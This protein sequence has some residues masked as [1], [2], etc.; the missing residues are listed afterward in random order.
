MSAGVAANRA[1]PLVRRWRVIEIERVQLSEVIHPLNELHVTALCASFQL[2]GGELLI[3]PIVVDESLQLIDGLHRITAAKRLGWRFISAVVFEQVDLHDRALLFAEAN[4][5]RKRISVLD[6]EREWRKLYAP[7]LEYQ[8][9]QRR[10]AGLQ[11]RFPHLSARASSPTA[12][13]VLPSPVIG[14]SNN[15]ETMGALEYPPRAESLAKAAKRITG[16]SI[17]TLN[18]VRAI[19]EIAESKKAPPNVQAAAQLGLKKIAASRASVDAVHRQLCSVMRSEAQVVAGVEVSST[20]KEQ[21]ET[22]VERLVVDVTL[23]AE[24]LGGS[25]FAALRNVAAE[26]ESAV[27][28]IAGIRSSLAIALGQVAAA[29]SLRSEQPEAEL[30][31]IMIEAGKL[32]TSTANER[33]RVAAQTP[34]ERLSNAA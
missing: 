31:R 30:C 9:K 19:R 33:L 15:R 4:R 13:S 34:S 27:Q 17:D 16:F 21:A 23:L 26:D 10:L 8:A 11:Q 5:V 7:E 18:K 3:Q 20:L 14:I 12:R 1:N 29:E 32:C 2:L 6:L 25:S 24:R 22:R 28:L